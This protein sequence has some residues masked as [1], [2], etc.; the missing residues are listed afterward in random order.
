M[1]PPFHV[2]TTNDKP[3]VN[4]SATTEMIVSQTDQVL[5]VSVMLI[6]K[7]SLTSQKPPSL[8]CEKIRDPAPV[9]IASNSGRTP[10]LC[11]AIGA[12]MPAA[13]VMATVDEPVARR[14]S[15]ASSQASNNSGTW[16]RIATRMIALETPLS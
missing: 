7:Y 9:A 1:L 2:R 3:T 11:S 4:R 5:I 10:V 16:L 13:V 8:T 12:T 6:S 15:A 14:I